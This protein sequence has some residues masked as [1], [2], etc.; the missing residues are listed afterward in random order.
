M[1]GLFFFCHYGICVIIEVTN[2]KGQ[3]KYGKKESNILFR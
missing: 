2:E 1:V 3:H